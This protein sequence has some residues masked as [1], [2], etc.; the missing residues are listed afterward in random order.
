MPR[1]HAVAINEPTPSTP[2]RRRAVTIV[3][4]MPSWTCHCLTKL[5]RGEVLV[6]YRGAKN[7]DDDI[8][9]NDAPKY[10]ALLTE[11]RD[12]VWRLRAKGKIDTYVRPIDADVHDRNDLKRVPPF[13]HVAIGK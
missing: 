2:R 5:R 11:I 3:E 1:I 8:K 4:A 10:C 13:E 6:Y 7:I 9:A 12:T